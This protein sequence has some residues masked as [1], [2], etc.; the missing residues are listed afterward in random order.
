MGAVRAAIRNAA[1]GLVPVVAPHEVRGIRLNGEE[2]TLGF[3]AGQTSFSRQ[4]WSLLTILFEH[5]NRFLTTHEIL[6]LGWR[7]GEFG[8][9][10]RI[11]IAR[12]RRKMTPLELPCTLVARHGSGYCLKF[13]A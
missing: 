8:P 13:A 4:E 12:L 6:R 5:P 2:G 3:G 9:E 11:Y 1:A 7:G 10:E